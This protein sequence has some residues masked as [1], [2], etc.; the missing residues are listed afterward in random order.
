MPETTETPLLIEPAIAAWLDEVRDTRSAETEKTY[1]YALRVFAAWWTAEQLSP[2]ITALTVAELKRYVSSLQG[3]RLADRTLHMYVDVLCRWLTHLVAQGELLGIPGSRGKLL[4]PSGVKQQ[5]VRTLAKLPP[6]VAPRMPDLTP[7]PAYYAQALATFLAGRGG[8][9][10]PCDERAAHRTYLNLL[11]NQALIAVLFSSGGRINE[12]LDLQLPQVRAHG[13]V[14]DAVAVQGKGRKKRS[15][16][17][18]TE[19]RTAITAYLAARAAAF[20]A[21]RS[22]FISHGPKASGARLSDTSAW[23]IVKAAAEA[24]ADVRMVAGVDAAELAALRAISPHSL[25]H[26]FAQGMLDEGADY[27]DIAAA[28]GH[29]STAVTEQVYAQQSVAQTLEVVATFAPRPGTTFE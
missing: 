23:R 17:L 20:P 11:R 26:F 2:A 21:A 15:I 18:N 4:A 3:R 28:L 16:Y 5:L 13:V 7:L 29:S 6:A 1:R 8:Q 24:L 19:T 25:R 12:L 9:V 27:K 14:R 10:P 22:L